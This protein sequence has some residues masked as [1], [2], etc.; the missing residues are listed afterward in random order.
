[1]VVPDWQN[2]GLAHTMIAAQKMAARDIRDM[3]RL[4]DL[5]H[6]NLRLMNEFT[7]FLLS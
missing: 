3:I 6:S 5:R 4:L 2:A 7:E 1:M